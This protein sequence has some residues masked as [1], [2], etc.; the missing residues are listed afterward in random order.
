MHVAQHGISVRE[1]SRV[2]VGRL[3]I[4]KYNAANSR[5]RQGWGMPEDSKP[6]DH[7]VRLKNVSTFT[8]K[9]IVA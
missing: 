7:E 4:L 9:R 1:T 5:S 2:V 6:E 8:R 3:A